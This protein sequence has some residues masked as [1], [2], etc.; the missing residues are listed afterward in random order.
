MLPENKLSKYPIVGEWVYDLGVET[1]PTLDY[2][3][4]GIALQDTSKGLDYQVWRGRLFSAGTEDSY[5]VLDGRFSPEFFFFTH[6]Y[7]TEFNFCFDFN[8]HPMAV[9]VATVYRE[10]PNGEILEEPHTY[11]RWFDTTI[12]RYDLI[13]LEGTVRTP[14]LVMD[15]PRKEESNFYEYSDVCLFYWRSGD[16]YVRYMRDRFTK[17][18]LLKRNIP[19]ISRVGMSTQTRLQIELIREPTVCKRG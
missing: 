19:Y 8:M 16:L 18:Y 3:S 10:L 2:K 12:G 9:F 14:K 11:L 5:I 15:D 7:M 1:T 17:D 4:G 6:P 13:E